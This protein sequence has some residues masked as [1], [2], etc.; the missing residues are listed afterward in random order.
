MRII[1]KLL[2]PMFVGPFEW[3]SLISI[4][5]W[6]SG[7]C[8]TA[9]FLFSSKLNLET[10]RVVA[11]FFI[12]IGMALLFSYFLTAISAYIYFLPTANQLGGLSDAYKEHDFYAPFR[13]YFAL[14]TS[15]IFFLI[16]VISFVRCLLKNSFT[17]R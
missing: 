3:I 2:P 5:F 7:A 13:I 8:I 12:Y 10:K 15:F 4:I 1:W 11:D 17:N 6:F 14:N 16:I 9:S